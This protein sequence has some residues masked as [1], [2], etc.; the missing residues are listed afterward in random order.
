M[1]T[2]DDVI[3][4]MLAAGM[5]PLPPDFPRLGKFIRF[6]PKKQAWY[7]LREYSTKTG[8]RLYAGSFG[9]WRGN[10]Q[11]TIKIEF[12]RDDIDHGELEAIR[13]RHAEAEAQ[14][15]ARRIERAGFAANRA[16]M[17]WK[18]GRAVGESPYLTRKGVQAEKGLRF[19][20]E[21]V[22]LV[23]M[24]RYDAPE[25]PESTDPGA[26][27]RRLVGL[28][29][30]QPDGSKLFNK[31]MEKLGAACRL[32]KAPKD[33]QPILLTEGVATAL[34]IRMATGKS[35][36]VFVAF[37][38]GNLL[39]VAKILRALYPKSPIVFCADD[40]AYVEAQ[41]NKMLRKQFDVE[42]LVAVPAGDLELDTKRGKVVLRA[43]FEFDA[44]AIQ[45][46]TGAVTSG[47]R[48]IPFAMLNA[49]RTKA[50]AAAREVGNARVCWPI[51]K[52]RE[53]H[54]D[55]E[56]SKFTDFNDLHA[57]E[58]LDA[59]ERQITGWLNGLEFTPTKAAAPKDAKGGEGAPPGGDGVDWDRFWLLVNRFTFIYPTDTAYDHEL[60]DIVK[61]EHMR[62]MFGSKYVQMWLGSEKRRAVNLQ[63]VVFE[64][65]VPE[66]KGKLNLFRSLGVEP[67]EGGCEKLLGLL[68]FLCNEDDKVFDWVLKWCAY[69][70]Q[71]LGAKMQTAVVMS[72][73]EGAGKNLFF[74][75]LR[76]IYGQ[77]GG[78]ITQRQLES[79]FMGWLSAKLFIIAN[80]VVSRAEMRHHV[81]FLRNLITEEE[82]WINRKNKDE[83]CEANHCNI[84][85]FSN[86]LQPLQ[87][88]ADDRRYMVIKTP[89]P[90][91]PEYYAAV[92]DEIAAGG[93][94][95]LL[96]YLLELDLDDFSPHTKPIDTVAKRD[97][98][99]LGMNAPQLLW[100]DI[101]EGEINL[102]YCPAL[103]EHVYRVFLSWCRRN[104][105]KMPARINRFIPDFMTLNGVR[106]KRMHVPVIE[107]MGG[108]YLGREER[109]Y[110]QVLLMGDPK[111]GEDV[112]AWVRRSV[113]EFARAADAYCKE[114]GS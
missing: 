111:D 93:A 26:M 7:K 11:G 89:P 70:L 106:R 20:S 36:T 9:E 22:L 100:R 64:P 52:D 83:R 60:G 81:G 78:V 95:A 72:G 21:G 47:D 1:A 40:D 48:L 44:D 112:D 71:H 92:R 42:Q 12:N 31:G 91:A 87:I 45:L 109:Q 76:Q 94:Q 69:P 24:I 50:C 113:I 75:V 54:C 67:A 18:A 23:P 98:I 33:G 99:D 102:P 114:S 30:I 97:L 10:D 6:G 3:N 2:L 68:Y 35:H 19:T 34:S 13:K 38:A 104:G 4:Q 46:I 59:V 79:D 86:E 39:P 15:E 88:N 77:H 105:E 73:K 55:P 14:E 65:G 49:G 56:G 80:E 16:M 108:E 107:R 57:I 62:L 37:D 58:G 28:Q 110:R 51:F 25:Q 43:Q 74:G 90:E 101:H 61:I 8:V 17:Q 27:Q 29:K 85:F 53:L 32:G 84:V 41:M 5:P 103:T 63:D 96:H 82:I 66:V